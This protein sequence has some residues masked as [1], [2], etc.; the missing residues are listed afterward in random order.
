MGASSCVTLF[1]AADQVIAVPDSAGVA[2]YVLIKEEE[3][4]L[5]S[6]SGRE[7]RLPVDAAIAEQPRDVQRLHFH[8]QLLSEKTMELRHIRTA[9]Q[10]DTDLRGLLSLCVVLC[11]PLANFCRAHADDGLV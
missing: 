10:F 1:P 5:R 4:H 2:G 9:G 8:L 11:K 6:R 3:K 7:W